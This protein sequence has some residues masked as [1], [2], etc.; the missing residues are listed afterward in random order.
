MV[1]VKSPA[2][3][4]ETVS[5]GPTNSHPCRRRI[6]FASAPLIDPAATTI[7][8]KT[9]RAPAGVA[10]NSTRPVSAPVFFQACG[11]PRGRK[12][13]E[14][15]PPTVTSSP[16]LKVISPLNRGRCA[17]AGAAANPRGRVRTTGKDPSQPRRTSPASGSQRTR[18]WREMDSNLRFPNGS[19][20]VFEIPVLPP[21]TV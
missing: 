13:Q 10:R 17:L 2:T 1:E 15:G 9:D 7:L 5:G 16:I 12:A 8:R 4:R 18:R 11:T 3:V 20:P 14:P 19:A 6:S 21:M